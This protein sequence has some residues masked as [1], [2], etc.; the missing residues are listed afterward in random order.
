MANFSN[1]A[2]VLFPGHKRRIQ[3]KT[4]TFRSER[5]AAGFF[6]THKAGS[7]E[8][9]PIWVFSPVVA[10]QPASRPAGRRSRQRQNIWNIVVS[11][12]QVKA[13]D[14]AEAASGSL[15]PWKIAMWGSHL[16]SRL[17]AT[18]SRRFD[19]LKTFCS[20]HELSVGEGFQLRTASSDEATD[21]I[22]ELEGKFEVDTK[23]LRKLGLILEFPSSSL[24]EDPQGQV[25]RPK[26]PGRNPPGDIPA[27]AHHRRQVASVCGLHGQIRSRSI[28]TDWHLGNRVAERFT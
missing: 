7:E 1:L 10:D 8:N 17:L 21:A 3:G 24:K 18:I 22:P 11:A 6:Y 26:K 13:V 12:N 20:R 14:V 25:F 16:D 9:R 27:T 19:D 5:P 23:A 2:Y 4:K 28:E 15:L